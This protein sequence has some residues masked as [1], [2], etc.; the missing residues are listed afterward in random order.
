MLLVLVGT[1]FPSASECH[2]FQWLSNARACLVFHV[3]GRQVPANALV[4]LDTSFCCIHLPLEAE[5]C[6]SSFWDGVLDTI[7]IPP[8]RVVGRFWS[9]YV[10]VVMSRL[11]ACT[12][13]CGGTG[14]SGN[15]DWG[16]WSLL[17]HASL[18]ICHP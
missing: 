7:S 2:W 4:P 18:I 16:T 12:S 13:A 14:R 1:A 3:L 6:S 15:A 9:L 17:F 11:T 5:L 8:S 10:L